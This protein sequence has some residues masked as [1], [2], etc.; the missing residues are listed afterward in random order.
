MPEIRLMRESV[1]VCNGTV[2]IELITNDRQIMAS[3]RN[4]AVNFF[5]KSPIHAGSALFWGGSMYRTTMREVLPVN[6]FFILFTT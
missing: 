3:P 2:K 4:R 1:L 5:E 6:L